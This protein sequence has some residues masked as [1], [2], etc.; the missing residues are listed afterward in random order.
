LPSGTGIQQGRCHCPI[1]VDL[2]R[3]E[4]A[5]MFL[6]VLVV[7]LVDESSNRPDKLIAAPGREIVAF[8]IFPRRVFALIEHIAPHRQ[9]RWNPVRIVLVRPPGKL[10]E[11][12]KVTRIFH[13]ANGHLRCHRPAPSRANGSMLPASAEGA[14]IILT[15][16][17]PFDMLLTAFHSSSTAEQSAVNRWVPGSNPGCGASASQPREAFLFC[18]T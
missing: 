16:V 17:K 4:P 2:E 18:A 10:K 15:L 11:R 12:R 5:D 7:A 6:M 13:F 3:D 9:Q 1:V 8:H 14:K